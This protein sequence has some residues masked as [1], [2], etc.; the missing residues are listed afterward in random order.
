M[1]LPVAHALVGAT[2]VTAILPAAS[3]AR[4]WKPLLIGAALSV[5]PDLDYFLDTTWHRGFTHS[6]ALAVVFAA[7]CF[8]PAGRAKI[9][10]AAAWSACFFSHA[11]LD[12]ATTKAM[13][14]VEL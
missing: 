3:P 5:C 14:G 8:A 9:R 13:P 11:L 6:L 4:N 7:V 10:V 1:P 12:F 2:I